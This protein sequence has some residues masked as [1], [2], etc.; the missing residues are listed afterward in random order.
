[1]RESEQ[2]DVWNCYLHTS[3]SYPIEIAI[4]SIFNLLL[5]SK[6][7]KFTALLR[8]CLFFGKF[9]VERES[10]THSE[11]NHTTTKIYPRLKVTQ[12]RPNSTYPLRTPRTRLRTKNDP[13]IMRVTKY[14]H[15]QE[16]PTASL[17]WKEN[18]NTRHQWFEHSQFFRF[19][20]RL[21][22][23]VDKINQIL[24]CDWLPEWERWRYLAR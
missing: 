16:L 10:S 20:T 14:N 8:S 23:R 5:F 19:I 1:M 21:A 17:I 12:T 22:W 2:Q 15:G 11:R 7:L 18:Q 6:L 9:S 3:L 4:I 24:C 13:Q